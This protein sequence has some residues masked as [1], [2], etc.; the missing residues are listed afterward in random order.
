MMTSRLNIILITLAI[1]VTAQWVWA[2]IIINRSFAKV[3]LG[4]SIQELQSLYA[5]KEIASSTLL[6]GERL[7]GID[8]QF[9]G[10][11]RVW[12]TFYLG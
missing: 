7:L 11:N 9:P 6:S 8:R 1:L 10:V 4:M 2:Q 12:C 3:T 5:T